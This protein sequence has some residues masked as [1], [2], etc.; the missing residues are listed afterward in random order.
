MEM[1]RPMADQV[2][3]VMLA[4]QVLQETF[5]QTTTIRRLR[6]IKHMQ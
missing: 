3:Q 2:E 1:V 6:H 4:M 5:H